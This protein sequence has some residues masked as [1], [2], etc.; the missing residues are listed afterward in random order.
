MIILNAV[1]GILLLEWAWKKNA[2]F[3]APIKE[4]DDLVP[5][6]HRA[7]AL[8]W[9]RWKFYPGAMTVMLPRFFL[10][11]I[12][13]IFYCTLIWLVLLGQPMDVQITGFRRKA[14]QIIYRFFGA[15]LNGILMF[16]ISHTK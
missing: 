8:R 14:L 9:A 15:T 2:R 16:T 5:E 3:R 13:S 4:L 11:V 6:F 12:V 7:D 1:L 10:S